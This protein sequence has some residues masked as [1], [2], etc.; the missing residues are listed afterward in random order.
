MATRLPADE[1]GKESKWADIDD[2]EDDWAPE[3]VQW[4]DGTKSTVTAIEP[5]L[6]PQSPVSDADKPIVVNAQTTTPVLPPTSKSTL[7]PTKT[8]LKPGAQPGTQSKGPG[9]LVLKVSAER[10]PSTSTAPIQIPAK[11]PWQQLPPVDKASPLQFTPPAQAPQHV[12]RDPNAYEPFPPVSTKEI[13][14]DDFNRGWDGE[15]HRNRALFNSQSG[16]LESV[17]DSRKG[18]PRGEQGHRQPAV[19]QRPSN[20]MSPAEPSAAF[21]TSRMSGQEPWQPRHRTGSVGSAGR[22]MSIGRAKDGSNERYEAPSPTMTQP[23]TSMPSGFQDRGPQQGPPQQRPW[24]R[25]SPSMSSAQFAVTER[26][27]GLATSESSV[28]P[29]PDGPEEDPVAMQQRLMREKIEKAKQHKQRE[30]EEERREEEARKQRLR[31]KMEELG[32][33][34]PSPT[35]EL[36]DP[37][38]DVQS[39]HGASP[40]ANKPPQLSPPPKP[41][42]PQSEGEVAQYGMMKVHQPHPVKKTTVTES[43]L[44][45]QMHNDGRKLAAGAGDNRQGSI[46]AGVWRPSGLPENISGWATNNTNNLWAPPQSS[47]DRALGNGTFETG[48]YGRLSSHS[49]QK[50]QVGGAPSLNAPGPIAPPPTGASQPPHAFAANSLPSAAQPDSTL[51]DQAQDQFSSSR[52]PGAVQQPMNPNYVPRSTLA[53]WKALPQR[54][55]SDQKTDNIAFMEQYRKTQASGF[56]SKPN[57]TIF[58]ETFT[59]TAPS[60]TLGGAPVVI[61]VEQRSLVPQQKRQDENNLV[62]GTAHSPGR[63]AHYNQAGYTGPRPSTIVDNV[64]RINGEKQSSAPAMTPA[65]SQSSQVGTAQRA[66]RFFPKSNAMQSSDKS[67]SPPPPENSSLDAGPS[68][69][70]KV[71]L[72][73]I[74]V[75][76]L[77]PARLS[78]PVQVRPVNNAALARQINPNSQ[79]PGDWQK[80]IDNLLR[81]GRPQDTSILGNS[82]RHTVDSASR[83]PLDVSASKISATVSLPAAGRDDYRKKSLFVVDDS[84]AVHSKD[85][86]E[87]LFPQPEFGSRPTIAFPRVAYTNLSEPNTARTHHFLSNRQKEQEKNMASS[88]IFFDITDLGEGPKGGLMTVTIRPVPGAQV[89]TVN[90]LVSSRSNSRGYG[91]GYRGRRGDGTNTRGT[92]KG[93]GQYSP[94][95]GQSGSPR[96]SIARASASH[97]GTRGNGFG[98]RNISAP[99]MST[100]ATQ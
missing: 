12:P 51:P 14:A 39:T 60:T 67:D 89:K 44:M 69:S 65:A 42:V 66:S 84:Q 80:K 85:L 36:R 32:G 74:A 46:E 48:G 90:V 52:M 8:I 76:K 40:Q 96:N 68:T 92:R 26:P 34:T 57:T 1:G 64:A 6:V 17:N 77:P 5:R 31:R 97:R 71:H 16:L 37:K 15:P 19:L 11:S 95:E 63:P 75:V 62:N 56:Q 72:P 53:D 28:P 50:A 23:H 30:L 61:S 35:A 38:R 99:P 83:A 73:K 94:R 27:E 87:D 58:D 47:K 22:R 2:D 9:T 49:R 54:L 24:T 86:D 3:P 20:Q 45:G 88:K 91:S 21:Q 18:P 43:S 100:A 78:E 79:A 82:L 25:T 41:P 70:P 29:T 4:L 93:S 59:R 55:A 33:N 81:P 98:R 10:P 7:P 13:A